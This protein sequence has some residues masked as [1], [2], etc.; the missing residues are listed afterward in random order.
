VPVS[1]LDPGL[2][3]VEHLMVLAAT[4]LA[5]DDDIAALTAGL[6]EVLQ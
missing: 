1:R 4:E 2:P 5:T 3:E 6:K